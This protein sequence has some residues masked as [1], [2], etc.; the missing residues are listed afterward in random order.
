MRLVLADDHN[1]FREA[2]CFYLRQCAD[3][4]VI[5]EARD[6]DG[7]LAA[8]RDSE[9]DLLLLDFVMPG[10]QGAAGV[11]RACHAIPGSPVVVLSGNI[12]Q[13]E[14]AEALKAGATSVISKDLSGDALRDA[15]RRIL[16]G[17]RLVAAPL[18]HA[19]SS[20]QPTE[21]DEEP[22]AVPPFR[23]TPRELAA[24]RL[25][26]Q[27]MA[28]KA[29]GHE[30]GIAAVTVRLHLYHAFQ[31]MGARNRVDAARIALSAGLLR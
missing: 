15:L 23:L 2:L 1:L 3:D 20:I 17:E 16:A 19:S 13:E 29:I 31:K 28:D 8:A 9:P 30:L 21:S 11:R 10:M 25:L 12:T 22:G 5:L 4:I 26:V 6:L 14:I 18:W 27:G 24:V 7:A